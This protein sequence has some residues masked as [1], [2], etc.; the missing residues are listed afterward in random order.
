MLCLFV[1]Q[2]EN[3]SSCHDFHFFLLVLRRYQCK[4]IPGLACFYVWKMGFKSLG[5]G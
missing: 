5:I 2:L 1:N 3:T 4:R